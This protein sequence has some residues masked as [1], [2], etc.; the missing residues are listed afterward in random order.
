MR[1]LEAEQAFLG[2][3]LVNND[4]LWRAGDLT[5]DDFSEP[6]HALIFETARV[7]IEKGEAANPTALRPHLATD[8]DVAAMNRDTGRDYLA[9]LHSGATTISGADGYASIIR[10]LAVRR[11]LVSLCDETAAEARDVRPDVDADQLIARA[12]ARIDSIGGGGGGDLESLGVAAERA[13]A[14]LSAETAQS[15]TTT[16]IPDLDDR[17]GGLRPGDLVVLAGRTG[18]GKSALAEHIAVAASDQGPVAMF[19]LEMDAEDLSRRELAARTGIAYERISQRRVGPHERASLADAAA[20]MGPLPV[21]VNRI[22]DLTASQ[23]KARARG[24]KHRRGGLALVVVDYLQL[25]RPDSTYRGNRVLEVAEITRALKLMGQQLEVPVL[26]LSQLN[27][28]LE[29]RDDKRPRLSDL[30]ES[31]AIEQDAAVVLFAHREAAYMERDGAR[32]NQ[33]A[34]DFMADLEAE[35]RLIEIIVAK[36]RHG[37]TGAVKVAADMS[38]NRFGPRAT[39][40]GA[41]TL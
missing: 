12:M 30:R 1:N 11:R 16:G 2:A 9:S 34:D 15:G 31:G 7:L 8:P 36:N 38:T 21:Y 26:A 6:L 40:Q 41:I 25:V 39:R 33:T 37:S 4:V 10:G 14:R 13:V 20:A 35:K 3:L 5:A 18:M 32:K 29:G 24:L 19:S 23:I 22:Y 28:E 17:L 27:R